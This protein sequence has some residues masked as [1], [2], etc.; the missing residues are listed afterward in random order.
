MDRSDDISSFRNIF[1]GAN[2]L[3]LKYSISELRA[4]ILVLVV[5]TYLFD[6]L[7]SPRHWSWYISD[8]GKD[9]LSVE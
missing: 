8:V 1:L 4:R 5:E 6:L 7:L 3:N 9:R 2:I